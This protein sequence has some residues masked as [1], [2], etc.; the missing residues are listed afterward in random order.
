MNSQTT[1]APQFATIHR[2][3]LSLRASIAAATPLR[4]RLRR[5]WSRRRT[6]TTLSQLSDAILRDIGIERGQIPAIARSM[7]ETAV[8]RSGAVITGAAAAVPAATANRSTVPASRA[9]A[10]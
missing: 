3:P 1:T 6:E 2:H 7:A 9:D 8:R 5:W 4:L 10:A